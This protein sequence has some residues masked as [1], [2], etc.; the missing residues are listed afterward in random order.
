MSDETRTQAELDLLAALEG[1][2]EIT[3]MSLSRRM[4]VSIGLVN[5]LLKRAVH[6]GFVKVKAAPRKRYV[7]YVTPKGFREKA[8]LVADYLESSLHFFR[9]AR[10][11]FDELLAILHRGG[12]RRVAVIGGGELMEIL[13][14]SQR[15][16]GV[17]VFAVLDR[18][19]NKE[20]LQ[21]VPVVRS[22]DELS[23]A[24]AVI[25]A[26]ARAPQDAFD[27]A[28]AAFGPG[29]VFAPALLRIRRDEADA[30]QGPECRNLK[31]K[32]QAE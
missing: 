15:D 6:K 29:R 30:G 26:D 14:L 21:G 10:A 25:V 22:F 11:Q 3:Q 9:K 5:A 31:P 4:M 8:R 19:T 18:A 27:R 17:E 1:G 2:G 24:D 28:C 20:H 23:D 16:S 12:A 7:Y 13:M 32:T